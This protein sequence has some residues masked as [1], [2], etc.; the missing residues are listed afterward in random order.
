MFGTVPKPFRHGTTIK[1]FFP[2]W[3]ILLGSNYF[4]NWNREELDRHQGII[5]TAERP[6]GIILHRALSVI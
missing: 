1:R 6:Q 2:R 4:D 5:E 3:A